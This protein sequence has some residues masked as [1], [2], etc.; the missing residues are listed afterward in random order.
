MAR[1]RLPYSGAIMLFTIALATSPPAVFADT[2]PGST[3]PLST[4]SAALD[5][6]A[7]AFPGPAQDFNGYVSHSFTVDGCGVCVVQPK[8]SLPGRPW[9]WRTMFWNAFPGADIA[10]LKA[11][12]Y[13]AFMDV[14]NTFGCPDAMKHFD[15]F[16]LAMTTQYGLSARPA[17]E[18][19]SRG[20]LYA[21]RWAY[22]NTDKV[23]CIYGDAPVCDMKSW[24]GGK[25]K[26]AGSPPDWQAAIQAYH[27]GGER[28]MMEFTGN[29][30]DILAPIAAAHIP[31]I[32]VC[33]DADSTVPESENTDIVRDRYEKMG[34]AFVLIVKHGCDHHPHG[35][36]DPTPVVNFIMAHC[37]QGEAAEKAAALAPKPGAVITLAQGQW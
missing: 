26:G 12:F 24:P 19:L 7:P 1:R 21:Y 15:A 5:G 9:V 6:S 37:A 34:G 23:G 33:G 13:V 31:I 36:A 29:P 10:L 18:G 3:G 4:S 20:G 30:I 32:H 35:L 27:F 28:E 16:Y 22:V 17:L 14:G 2:S 8:A 11:G 25:G